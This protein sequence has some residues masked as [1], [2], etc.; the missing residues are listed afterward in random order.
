MLV[1]DITNKSSTEHLE[2]WL[3]FVNDN[4][5]PDTVCVL[6]GNKKDLEQ[7]RDVPK[8]EGKVGLFVLESIYEFY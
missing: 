8:E 4:A 5:L 1:F 6:L 7:H 2:T 3:N